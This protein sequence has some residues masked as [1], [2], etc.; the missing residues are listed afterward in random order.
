[1]WL[2]AA[3]APRSAGTFGAGVLQASAVVRRDIRGAELAEV[4]NSSLDSS[5]LGKYHSTEVAN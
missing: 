5:C 4:A 2:A 1:M 3:A